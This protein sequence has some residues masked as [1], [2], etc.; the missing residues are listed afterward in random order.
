MFPNKKKPYYIGNFYHFL[1]IVFKNENPLIYEE[2][3]AI[4][5]YVLS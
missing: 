1:N 2:V 4:L 5:F 3:S